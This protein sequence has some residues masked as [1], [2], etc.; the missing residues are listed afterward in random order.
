[1]RSFVNSLP[2]VGGVFES[3][4]GSP[5][6]EAKQAAMEQAKQAMFAY[7]PMAMDTRMNAM[8]N[9]AAAFGPMQQLMGQM[10]GQGAQTDMSKLISNPFP[11]RMQDDMRQMAKPAQQQREEKVQRQMAGGAKRYDNLSDLMY[12][13]KQQQQQKR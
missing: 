7:R 3:I 1:M 5:E 12:A 9:S 2:V 11:D 8:Q 4:W 6:Q 10:Y 13:A